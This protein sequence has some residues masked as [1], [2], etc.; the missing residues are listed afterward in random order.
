M[1]RFS[2]KVYQL[3]K[4]IPKGKVTTYG[5]LAVLLGKPG[6]ARAV[7]QALNK[8]PFAPE[9][10][11]HRVI[12]IDG[13]LCGFAKGLRVK[14]ELLKAEGVEVI[15]GRVDLKNYLYKR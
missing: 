8:N 1:T 15:G 6:A 3:T 11:C 5:Q 12:G 2:K 9:V 10:P 13:N 4:Q 14:E 7:G